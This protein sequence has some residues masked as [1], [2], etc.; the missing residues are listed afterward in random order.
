MT[1]ASIT[2]SSKWDLCNIFSTFCLPSLLVNHPRTSLFIF[3]LLS[4]SD[5]VGVVVRQKSVKDQGSVL[6]SSSSFAGLLIFKCDEIR[7]CSTPLKDMFIMVTLQRRRR[8]I[9]QIIPAISSTYKFSTI[10]RGW[11]S[12]LKAWSNSSNSCSHSLRNSSGFVKKKDRAR[13]M[14]GSFPYWSCG[15]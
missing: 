4:I 7:L 6:D 8:K 2:D 3:L 5:L 11:I 15:T 1:S 12:P 9:S 10:P 14:V 13:P